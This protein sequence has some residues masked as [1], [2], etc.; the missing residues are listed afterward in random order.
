MVFCLNNK[1]TF[2]QDV[3]CDCSSE[4]KHYRKYFTKKNVTLGNTHLNWLTQT[5]DISLN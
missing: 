2:N 1:P 3:S 4:R 5:A